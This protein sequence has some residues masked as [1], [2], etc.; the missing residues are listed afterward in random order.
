MF[1]GEVIANGNA[2]VTARG[3][4]IGF[5]PNPSINNAAVI[6]VGAGTGA[7]TVNVIGMSAYTPTLLLM[8]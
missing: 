1:N 3:F 2:A 4:W 8:C 7:F 6:N 5:T